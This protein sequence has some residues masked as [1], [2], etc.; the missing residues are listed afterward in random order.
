MGIPTVMLSSYLNKMLDMNFNQWINTYR[1]T[2]VK[3]LLLTTNSTLDEIAEA[4]G[5]TTR[6]LLSRH[7]KTLEGTSPSEFRI[8]HRTENRK[9]NVTS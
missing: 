8:M 2:H 5:F 9:T 6:S 7:F 3:H 1:I 4:T